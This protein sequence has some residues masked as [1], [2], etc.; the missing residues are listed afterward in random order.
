MVAT[1]DQF[2]SRPDDGDAVQLLDPYAKAGRR[3]KLAV[4]WQSKAI[5]RDLA[6][7]LKS[8]LYV[9]NL[10][11]AA[12]DLQIEVEDRDALWAGDWRPE[13]GDTVT[14]RIEVTEAWFGDKVTALRLGT[15][16]HDRITLKGPPRT[17][18]LSCV[19]AAISTGLRRR[20]RTKNWRKVTLKQIAEDIA[21]RADLTLEFDGAAG[22]KY[23]HVGQ[24]N[25]SDLEFLEGECAK[26]GRTLKVTESKIVIY[27]EQAL[28]EGDSVG[29]ID[30]IG[31][32]VHELEFEA[33]D[34][35][36]YGSCHVSC[37]NPRTGK[38]V[39]GQFP[40]EGQV[41]E[42]LDPNGQ[43][44]EL[45]INVTDAAEASSRAE[46]FLRNANRFA[47]RGTIKTVGAPGLVAGTVFDLVNAAGLD[48]KF[49]VTR[50]E[51]RP[52]GGYTTTINV[53][54]C[55]EGY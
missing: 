3:V 6:P 49:I 46:K 10:S 13:T 52:I 28:D 54:R 20:K 12:D 44:L 25:Q 26:A 31:G 35:G 16:F 36:R 37:F 50:A 51:H 34:A 24:H 47:T 30:L 2:T 45:V 15:F 7:H 19:S 23:Q 33:G 43:T 5:A 41:V 1:L 29:E 17:V 21:D 14:A 27:D 38:T 4:S 32:W 40:R 18:N 53:R 48:G 8:L 39:N 42:G 22:P 55:L 9:D 11:G